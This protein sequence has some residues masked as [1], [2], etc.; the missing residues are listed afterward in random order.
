MGGGVLVKLFEP[1]Q[2]NQEVLVPVHGHRKRSDQ[3]LCLKHVQLVAFLKLTVEPVDSI[4]LFAEGVPQGRSQLRLNQAALAT[5]DQIPFALQPYQAKADIG[6]STLA[7][8]SSVDRAACEA[9][10]HLFQK[11]IQIVPGGRVR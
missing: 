7:H 11:D 8:L 1:Q 9:S 6:W 5:V 2:G 3:R 4:Q 10:V